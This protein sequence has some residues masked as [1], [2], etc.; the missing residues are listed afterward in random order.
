M[1][2]DPATLSNAPVVVDV[3]GREVV[4]AGGPADPGL[5]GQL[6]FAGLTT[7]AWITDTGEIVREESPLGLD[8][9]ARDARAGARAGGVEPRAGRHAGRRPR[10][11]RRCARASTSHATWPGCAWSS[12]ASIPRRWPARRRRAVLRRTTCSSCVDAAAVAARP[13][14]SRP[15]ALPAPRAAHRKRRPG[16][17]RRGASGWWRARRAARSRRAARARRQRPARQDADHQRAL[18]KRGAAHEGRRLQRAHGALRGHGARRRH[19]HAHQRRPGLSSAARSTT[20]PGPRCTS[21]RATAAATGCRSIPTFN[22]FPADATH[23]RLLQRRA[24]QADGHPAAH[25]PR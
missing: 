6:G 7:T 4:L 3:S 18:G 9:G 12:A 21:T 17:C 25:R 5:Q 16:D 22:Q 24:R 2:F 8:V 19:P 13:R 14:R 1:V 20:T 10:S 23:L 11:C 15:G